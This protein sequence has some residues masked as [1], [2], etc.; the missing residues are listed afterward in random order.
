MPD[1][2]RPKPKD[3]IA[4]IGGV[5]CGVN[6]PFGLYGSRMNEVPYFSMFPP[7]YYSLPVPRTYGWSPSLIRR[8]P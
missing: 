5:G 8:E 4:V 3:L 7:V 1:T 6:F 2:S